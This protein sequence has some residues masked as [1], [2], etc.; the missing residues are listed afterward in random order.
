[1]QN[2]DVVLHQWIGP[3]PGINSGAE[4]NA[5]AELIEGCSR[6]NAVAEPGKNC[7]GVFMLEETWI[8]PRGR[9]VV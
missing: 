8:P 4:S 3:I 2:L 5:L 6:L 7:R 1:M 9:V